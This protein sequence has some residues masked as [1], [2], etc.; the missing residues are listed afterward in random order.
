MTDKRYLRQTRVSNFGTSGQKALEKAKVL[1]IGC[2]GLG[3]PVAMYLTR[4]GIRHIGLVDSDNVDITNLHRQVLFNESDVGSLKAVAAKSHLL[5][6]DKGLQID[7]FT[8]RLQAENYA[9][10]FE[11][12]DI[13]VD[14]TDNFETRYLVN[15]ACI[16]LDKPLIY[17]AANGWQGQIAVFNVKGSGNLRDLYPE[18]PTQGTIQ[19]C[20]EA[21]VLGPTTGTIGNLM[22][23]E[24]IKVA[25]GIGS[26]LKNQILQFDGEQ[27]IFHKLAYTPNP[28][29]RNVQV[30]QIRQITW[31]AYRSQYADKLLVDVRTAV[32]RMSRPIK[33]EHIPIDNMPGAFEG[34]RKDKQVV[35]FCQTGQRALSAAQMATSYFDKSPIA[36]IDTLG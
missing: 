35:F 33:S 14:C 15:D 5:K 24:V 19:N 2:G 22:A 25:T 3:C 13:I 32:E 4:A 7:V 20:E 34:M 36:I 31:N 27:N 23:L 11:K 6:A 30:S 1:V 17:G 21:G 26:T 28:Q 12:F 18:I 8:D 10:I 29:T 16:L 9:S